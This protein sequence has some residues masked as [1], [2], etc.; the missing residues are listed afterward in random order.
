MQIH[1]P[2]YRLPRTGLRQLHIDGVEYAYQI[3]GDRVLFF[4]EDCKLVADITEV[5]GRSW[6]DIERGRHK[7]TSDGEVKPRHCK[8]FLECYLTKT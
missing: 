5:T 3:A 4:L 2:G 6:V 7:R 1:G 8:A